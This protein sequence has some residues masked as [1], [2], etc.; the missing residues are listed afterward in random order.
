MTALMQVHYNL[1][2]HRRIKVQQHALEAV[3]DQMLE[4]RKALQPTEEYFDLP[5]I[6]L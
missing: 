5:A 3:A 1:V 4:D 6:A 2:N